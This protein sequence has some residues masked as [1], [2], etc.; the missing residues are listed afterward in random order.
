MRKRYVNL[1][2]IPSRSKAILSE[3][4]GDVMM[5]NERAEPF[6][7]ELVRLPTGSCLECQNQTIKARHHIWHHTF[8]LLFPDTSVQ[9]AKVSSAKG[10]KPKKP[11]IGISKM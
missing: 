10:P 6:W 4:N 7:L 11:S 5:S 8:H 2:T 9:K 3:D 1:K